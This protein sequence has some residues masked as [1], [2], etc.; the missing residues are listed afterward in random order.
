MQP[1][2]KKLEDIDLSDL[3]FWMAPIEDREGAFLTLRN[4]LDSDMAHDILLLSE[5]GQDWEV[6]A[7]E[8]TDTFTGPES[9]P[10]PW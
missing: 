10:R 1:R 5:D 3:E 9:P 4:D 6:V 7:L 8:A 2:I